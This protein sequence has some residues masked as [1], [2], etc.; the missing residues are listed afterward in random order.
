MAGTYTQ[1]AAPAASGLPP[2]PVEPEAHPISSGKSGQLA[3]FVAF[4]HAAREARSRKSGE[5][6][7][8]R[9]AQGAVT[10]L[11]P[12]EIVN[13]ITRNRKPVLSSE[14]IQRISFQL[15]QKNVTNLTPV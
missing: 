15:E 13:F 12:K 14:Q 11:N 2:K 1:A 7:I 10:V 5:W 8:D 4:L 3:G 9:E 6:L